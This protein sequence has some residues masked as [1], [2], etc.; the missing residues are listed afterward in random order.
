VILARWW[1][2]PA[3]PG[4]QRQPLA[5]AAVPA[6]APVSGDR[7]DEQV[8]GASDEARL[9]WSLRLRAGWMVAVLRLLAAT[10]RVRVEGLQAFDAALAARRPSLLALWHGT[11]IPLFVLLAGRQALVFSSRSRR[12]MV[13]AEICRRCGYRTALLAD[14]GGEGELARMREAL[15][16]QVAAG[17]AVDGPLGPP[18]Q[19][20]RGAVQ[21][22]VE[23]G[24]L[25]FP[26]AVAARPAWVDR[27][28]WDQ[29]TVPW[30][31]ARVAVALGEPLDLGRLPVPAPAAVVNA[32]RER[33]AEALRCAE[34]RAAA[35]L[36]LP[37][38][39]SPAGRGEV[40][41]R[42]GTP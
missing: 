39:P 2:L 25:L 28:R 7:R 17:I 8:P 14:R 6:A 37:V 40:E 13:I 19:V 26:L 11:Y 36:D 34:V 29:R 23:E 30:P 27:R 35:L 18:R 32:G 12:G 9:P 31:F 42:G 3:S 4:A 16:G 15:A 38:V 5:P 10:W 21:L 41:P 1:S 22:A 33:L 20:K 24:R